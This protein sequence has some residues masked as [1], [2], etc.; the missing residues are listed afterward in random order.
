MPVQ[1]DDLK[2]K[3]GY[4]DLVGGKTSKLQKAFGLK[5]T[6][7]EDAYEFLQKNDVAESELTKGLG[8]KTNGVGLQELCEALRELHNKR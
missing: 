2:V 3:E 5:F 1:E 7:I 6:S 4:G 8:G